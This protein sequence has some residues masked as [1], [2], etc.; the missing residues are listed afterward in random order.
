MSLRVH[1]YE[2]NS[3]IEESIVELDISQYEIQN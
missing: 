2:F 3:V 1:N